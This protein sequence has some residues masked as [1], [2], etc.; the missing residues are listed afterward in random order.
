MWGFFA[1]SMVGIALAIT[2]LIKKFA[3]KNVEYIIILATVYAWGTAM[4]IIALV[5]MDVW[6]TKEKFESGAIG[7]M[8]DVAYWSTQAG[9]WLVLPFYQVYSEAGDFT[10]KNKAWTSIKE[11]AILYGAVGVLGLVG[12]S[13]LLFTHEFSIESLLGLGIFLSN[14]FGLIAGILLLGYGLVEIPR[15]MWKTSDPDTQLKWCVH[16]ADYS[17]RYSPVKPSSMAQR[18]VDIDSIKAEDLEYNFDVNGLAALRRRLGYAIDEYRGNRAQYV[19]VMVEAFELE[20]VIQC[21]SLGEYQPRTRAQYVDVMVEAFELEDVIKCRSL[22]EY[23][24][25]A[26]VEIGPTVGGA[27]SESLITGSGFSSDHHNPLV[28]PI[29]PWTRY[30]WLYKCIARPVANKVFAVLLAMVSV[31]IVFA[32]ATIPFEAV[33]LSP[34][35]QMVIRA[36]S[37][38]SVQLLVLLPL[39][40][41]CASSYFALFKINA[42]NYNKLVP[43]ATTGA[44]LMQNGYHTVFGTKMAFMDVAIPNVNLNLYLPIVLL[45]QCSLVALNLWD[46]ALYMCVSSKYK[47]NSDDVDDEYTVKGRLLVRKEQEAANMGHPIGEVLH[48]AYFDLEFPTIAGAFKASTTKSKGIFGFFKSKK[49][50]DVAAASSSE[51]TG[52]YYST[53]A[54]QAAARWTRGASA[55][56]QYGERQAAQSEVDN[57]RQ[58]LLA[59]KHDQGARAGGSDYG[60]ASSSAGGGGSKKLDGIFASLVAG[61]KPGCSPTSPGDKGP[62]GSAASGGGDPA[63]DSG[64]NSKEKNSKVFCKDC[65]S[66]TS[67]W[68]DWVMSSSLGRPGACGPHDVGGEDDSEPIDRAEKKYSLWEKEIHVLLGTLVKKR[69]LSMDEQR[70]AAEQLPDVDTLSYYEKWGHAM[71]SIC[72]ERGIISAADLDAALGSVPSDNT[73]RFFAGGLV[74]VRSEGT[75]I[76][77]RKPHLRTPGYLHA[78]VGMVERDCEGSY[79]DPSTAAFRDPTVKQPLYRVRFHQRD[80]WEHYDGADGDTVDVDIFQPW[81]EPATQLELAEQQ[82]A[83]RGQSRPEKRHKGGDEGPSHQSLIEE[84]GHESLHAHK[85]N[86]AESGNVEDG[87]T[88]EGEEHG[89][90]HRTH[91][92]EGAGHGHTHDAAGHGHTHEGAGHGHTHDARSEVEQVAVDREGD[93]SD[94]SRFC[95]A[96]LVVMKGKG[97]IS[98]E[99]LRIGVE[100]LESK[101]GQGGSYG[102]RVVARAWVDPSFKERLLKD[103]NAAVAELGLEGSNYPAREDATASSKPKELY[104]TILTVVENTTSV[105]NLVVCTL[106]SC[107]PASLLGTSPAWYKSRSYRARAARYP[108]GV[109]KEFDTIIPDDVAVR[110]HDSTAD[111]RYLVLPL[112]PSGTQGFSEEQL[113]KL[114]TRDSMIGVTTL[115]L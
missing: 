34:F 40:Y 36:T 52:G 93:V 69:L 98:A 85:H 81:L 65:R 82:L 35:S 62:F 80:L 107:Y 61:S 84:D 67:I 44:A 2:G 4:M 46:K 102:A 10:V 14:A 51:R 31:G 21:R 41:I 95:E 89:H 17:E 111:N 25:R 74:R 97:I 1:V 8:W 70:R 94:Q 26:P 37:E 29:R 9:T 71:A 38:I 99:E 104:G 30:L 68:V 110:V 106:C 109:L 7:I 79:P 64:A 88:H 11:N 15:S 112:R 47:F 57:P 28:R 86:V 42:F 43:R 20:D 105:H 19:D 23:E 78:L 33:N 13:I 66:G 50:P 49:T 45:I 22:G 115:S 12:I 59:A 72:L 60:E 83:W 87:N 101:G 103:A 54:A 48:S 73:T 100:V 18:N 32:E 3:A 56:K 76:R 96:L 24:P 77:W 53:A 75:A 5:P 90:K 16:R 113:A 114:V 6:A 55:D 91:V 27:D 58:S 39:A 108:R 92:H 63:Q